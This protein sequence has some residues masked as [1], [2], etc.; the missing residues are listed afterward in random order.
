MR[1]RKLL[2]IHSGRSTRALI[3][4][5]IY[6]E[7][8]DTE[9][10]EADSGHS[11]LALIEADRF[12]V[13]ISAERLEDTGLEEFANRLEAIKPN[14]QAA[15]III[16]DSETAEVREGLLRQGFEKIVQI[17][18]RPAD[19]IRQINA[20]CDPRKWRKD[21]RYHIPN[22]A[23]AVS[24]GN[25]VIEAALINISMG[26][27][28]VELTTDDPCALMNGGLSLSL[29]IPLPNAT[30]RVDELSTKLLRVETVKWTAGHIPKAMRATFI[31]VDLNPGAQGKLAELIQMAKE[32]KL[33]ATEV[34][35]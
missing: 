17:R 18:I 10:T 7:L 35:D 26:G 33:S 16:T 9:I 6:A 20:A 11:A 30:A 28:L 2:L 15:L 19:L 5:Y 27:V 24:S 12:D 25:L 31:F 34:L 3:K 8:C 21:A 29:Q 4:K 14:G 13:I 32:E 23:V 1:I 22:A